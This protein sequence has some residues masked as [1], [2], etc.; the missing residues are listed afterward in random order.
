MSYGVTQQMI[1]TYCE[2]IFKLSLNKQSRR[3]LLKKRG[4]SGPC[5]KNL[6]NGILMIYVFMLR[7]QSECFPVLDMLPD[8]HQTIPEV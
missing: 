8:K 5:C 2:I 7:L 6:V 1:D 4:V 3:G